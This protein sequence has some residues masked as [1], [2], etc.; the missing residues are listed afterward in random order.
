[1]IE[2][3]MNEGD[4]NM[5]IGIT[6]AVI[7]NSG[8]GAILHGIVTSLKDQ[9]V[10]TDSDIVVFDSN[11]AETARLYPQWQV[12]QQLTVPTGASNSLPARVVKRGHKLLTRAIA[13]NPR[14]G[15]ALLARGPLRSTALGQSYQE[16]LGC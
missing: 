8:D 16:L 10:C 6:N 7:S 3:A 1:M 5:R 14:L 4:P 15:N 2:P 9:G 12:R 13:R 11:A